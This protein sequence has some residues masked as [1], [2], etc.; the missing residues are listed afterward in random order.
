MFDFVFV[1]NHAAQD[2]GEDLK[3]I[4]R[5]EALIVAEL[6]RYVNTVGGHAA[7]L[8]GPHGRGMA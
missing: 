5:S 6:A 1:S 2:I 3:P 8:L 7:R 4:L